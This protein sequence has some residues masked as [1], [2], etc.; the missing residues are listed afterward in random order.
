VFI[1]L[2]FNPSHVM[3]FGE[4]NPGGHTRQVELQV[5]SN[6]ERQSGRGI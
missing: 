5:C 4:S 6:T 2:P 3:T 1:R